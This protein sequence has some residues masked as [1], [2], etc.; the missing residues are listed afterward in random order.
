MPSAL[1]P[2]FD[3][4]RKYHEVSVTT[5]APN[6][7][8]PQSSRA[9]SRGR[10]AFRRCCFGLGCLVV[11]VYAA[12]FLVAHTP[13]K[14]WLLGLMVRPLNVRPSI[15]ELSLGWFSPVRARG[16]ALQP[17]GHP[18]VL[19]AEVL[20]T[21]QPLWRLVFVPSSDVGVEIRRPELHIAITEHGSNLQALFAAASPGA[22]K[23]PRR[24]VRIQVAEGSLQWSPQ[25]A[26]RPW[27]AGPVD[28]LV[29]LVPAT[30][31]QPQAALVVAPG[32][33]LRRVELSRGMC[34]DVLKYVHPLFADVAQVSGR[35][36]LSL[37]QCRLPLHD[38]SSQQPNSGSPRTI[39]RAA[40]KGTLELHRVGVGPGPLIAEL[41]A[42]LGVPP[43]V[44]LVHESRMAFELRDARVYHERLEFSLWRLHVLTSG[45]VGL[46]ESLDLVAEIGLAP[47]M[48]PDSA[49][50]LLAALE[51]Q[52][53]RVRIAGTLTRPRVDLRPSGRDNLGVL[54]DVIHGL[55]ERLK[56]QQPPPAEEME[57]NVPPP[58]DRS[59]IRRLRD[60]I[61]RLRKKLPQP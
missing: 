25:R 57:P 12:P 8:V 45:Y 60:Q 42:L 16:F 4:G 30:P 14:T 59:R 24:H 38:S 26:E 6:A 19:Q 36:S 46:D 2:P 20:Q 48:K 17:P 56:Q 54:A 31:Q 15:Q 32:P 22:P 51:T 40:V 44:E 29:E 3:A 41:A 43:E 28:C 47:G 33:L 52:P 61:D 5:P 13:L 27:R 58:A 18:P 23:P 39:E 53:I 7:A 11:L 55:G 21:Q 49:Q 50:P 10:R 37:A 34:H 35:L 1:S 9:P